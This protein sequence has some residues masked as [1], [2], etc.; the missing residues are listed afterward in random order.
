M[1]HVVRAHTCFTC[2]TLTDWSDFVGLGWLLG[3]FVCF[4]FAFLLSTDEPVRSSYQPMTIIA[5]LHDCHCRYDERSTVQKKKSSRT[6]DMRAFDCQL[7]LDLTARGTGFTHPSLHSPGDC[8]GGF[9]SLC[10]FEFVAFVEK[11][12]SRIF[13]T[14][15]LGLA[16]RRATARITTFVEPCSIQGKNKRQYSRVAGSPPLYSIPHLPL[17]V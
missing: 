13:A 16:D 5:Y 12:L 8:I 7:A 14:S 10:C 9:V 2:F 17:Q 6:V 11:N 3:R 4:S 15:H 1:H